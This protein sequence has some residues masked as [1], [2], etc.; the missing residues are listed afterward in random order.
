MRFLNYKIKKI[1]KYQNI[2]GFY[3]RDRKARS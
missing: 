1:K 3:G 2:G